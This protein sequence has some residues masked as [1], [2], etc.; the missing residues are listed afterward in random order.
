MKTLLGKICKTLI[1]QLS[2][3]PFPIENYIKPTLRKTCTSE[4][5]CE[6]NFH[7]Y[8][9]NGECKLIILE[10]NPVDNTNI[11][12]FF[13]ERI[14]DEI[15]RNRL[16][17][18]EIL[19]DKLDELINKT[20]EKRNDEIIINGSKNLGAQVEELY[21]PKKEFI[22][23]KENM[24]STTQPDYKGV[25]KNKFLIQSH[26]FILDSSKLMVLPSYWKTIMGNKFRYY[27]DKIENNS[28][29]FAILRIIHMINP[30]IKNI[31]DLKRLE[32]NKIEH[33]SRDNIENDY[34][35][36]NIQPEIIDGI[37]RIIAIF[38]Y[39]KKIQYK[40]INTMTQLKE[41][42]MSE[43]YPANEVDVFLLALAL[44]INILILE[45]RI[46]KKNNDGFYIFAPQKNK[47]FIVLFNQSKLEDNNYNIV[48]K[49]NNY[50]F[51]LKDLPK[52]IQKF[53]GFE[54]TSDSN[55]QLQIGNKKMIKIKK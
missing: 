9:Q 22:L 16:L 32:I 21:K 20:I 42:I 55:N 12:D 40:S 29:Y 52:I 8:F 6:K 7:C 37:N 47:D 38:K 54:H 28:L 4:K 43:E 39:N 48:G 10:K 30:D 23:R 44:G 51:K 31:M 50:I 36:K 15:L 13:M 33:I 35:F 27:D 34:Y 45:K 49:Q 53:I 25:N 18:D 24:Y 3:L 14:S 19:E 2:K 17:R 26:E 41:F 46:T 11:F 5:K 1:V